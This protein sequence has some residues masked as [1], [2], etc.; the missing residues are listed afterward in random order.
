MMDSVTEFV[1]PALGRREVVARFDGGEVTSDAGL[2]LLAAA[3]RR[4]GVSHALAEA[5][6]DRRQPGKVR[7]PAAEIIAARV[8][9]I[10]CG[11]E[12][13]NDFDRL[14]TDPGL[15]TACGR[16]PSE[17][18]LVTQ[19]VIS[20]FEHAPGRR[21]LVC[22][23]WALAEVALGQLPE[24]EREIWID[25]D[26]YDDP[27]HGQQQLSLFNGH[28]D[29]RCYLPLA[30][31]ISGTDGV[32]RQLG[33]VLRPGNAGA[34]RGLG[35]VLRGLVRRLRRRCPQARL[36]LR[37]DSGYGVARVLAWCA[38]LRLDYVL[39][40]ARNAVLQELSTPTQMDAAL[41]W[42]WEGDGCRE[43]GE[44]YYAAQTWKTRARL[45]VKVEIT[46]HTLNPRFVVT[47][48]TGP[49][50]QVYTRY[51]ARGDRENRWKEFKGD[52]AAGRTSCTTFLANQCRLLWHVAAAL[53]CVAVREAAAGTQWATAQVNT[54]RTRL[55]KIAARVLQTARRIWW[56]L[57]TSCPVQQDWL[58]IASRLC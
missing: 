8:Y 19:E 30:V 43:F 18:P 10:A 55:F 28:Y 15:K 48:L 50:E 3:D 27:C 49:A 7:Y 41:K 17:A 12:D 21:E 33:A 36:I 31:C 52:L 5:Y 22:M 4:L 35:S 40:V 42:A 56:H 20:G 34:T 32:Q 54:L 45:I 57:P 47:S 44:F 37:G 51:C 29:A 53:L 26:A 1:F 16:L 25:V 13:G 11:Y 2:A 58:L 46:Q 38:R 14:R 39:G 24:T 9:A 6:D 23:G